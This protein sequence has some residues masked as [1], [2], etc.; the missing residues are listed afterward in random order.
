[1]KNNL[2]K[3][4]EQ[5][6]SSLPSSVNDED[7]QHHRYKLIRLVKN[8][9][10]EDLGVYLTM[11]IHHSM[12]KTGNDGREQTVREA[13]YVVVKLEPGKIAEK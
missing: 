10:D 11:K 3:S 12:T 4:Y 9:V 8:K 2:S 6:L 7:T 13:R 1:M 5:D